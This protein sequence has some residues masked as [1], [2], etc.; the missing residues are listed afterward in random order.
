MNNRPSRKEYYTELVLSAAK[1]SSCPRAQVWALIV[2]NWVIIST[3]YNWAA[4]W[5]KDCYE[6]GCLIEDWHCVRTIHAEENAI[7]NCARVWVSLEG[8]EMYVTHRP[9]NLCSRKIIN[10]WIKKVYF[11]KDYWDKSKRNINLEDYLEVEELS[12]KK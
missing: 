7:I 1:R 10:A 6:E 12:I 8:S 2:K 4:K 9:C 5:E 11:L 3:W